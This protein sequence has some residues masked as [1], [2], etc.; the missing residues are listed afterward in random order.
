[1]EAAHAHGH[2]IPTPLLDCLRRAIAAGWAD[3]VRL[4]LEYLRRAIAAGWADEEDPFLV[5]W[6]LE[7]GQAG[8]ELVGFLE[9]GSHYFRLGRSGICTRVQKYKCYQNACVH[10]G[11]ASIMLMWALAK[12]SLWHQNTLHAFCFKLLCNMV[13]DVCAITSVMRQR[14]DWRSMSRSLEEHVKNSG[15]AC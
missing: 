12:Q 3:Q 14:N 15:G 7:E 8:K 10:C 4:L 5:G 11:G 1:M 13:E 9:E 6:L 2:S